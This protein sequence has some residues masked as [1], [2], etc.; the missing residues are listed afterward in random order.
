METDFLNYIQ[1]LEMMAFFSGY[2]L[3][4][5]IILFI[6]GK[7]QTKTNFRSKVVSFL[8]F[9]YALVGTLFLVLQLRNLYPDYSIENIELSM[10]QPYL[11]TWALLSLLF[12][13]PILSKKPVL[14]L[15][16]S[17]IFF[18]IIARD[19]FLNIFQ[20]SS[21]YHSIRNDMKIYTDSLLLNTGCL[22]LITIIYLL[23]KQFN[24]GTASN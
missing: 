12:W 16:H 15:L 24:R 7:Q 17:F 14:S 18:F 22:F 4:Y 2:P 8:P 10:Q 21:N 9:A 6:A 5:S 20:S 23:I 3:L 11:K 1:Q 19:L 13:L